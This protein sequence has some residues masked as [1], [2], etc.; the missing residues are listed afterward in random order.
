MI[1]LLDTIPDIN[2]QPAEYKR[3]LGF[4]RERV[5]EGRSRELAEWMVADGLQVRLGLQ[6]H[7]FIWAP[8]MK[9]V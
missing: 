1:E 8:E 4:P 3:L 2:V 9:G 5:L 7:K 6:I